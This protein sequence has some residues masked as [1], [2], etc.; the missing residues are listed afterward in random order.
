[1]K[2]TVFKTSLSIEEKKKIESDLKILKK[3]IDFSKRKGYRPVVT[4]GYGLDGIIGEIT[5][6]HGDLDIVIYANH[7]RKQIV[8]E[9]TNFIET[10]LSKPQIST[11]S[12]KFVHTID[13]NS[14]GFGGNIY[15]V[16]TENDPHSDLNVIILENKKVHKN[17]PQQFP[18]P[19]SAKLRRLIFE[20]QDPNA[21]FADILFK[22][23]HQ[24]KYNK[25]KQDIENLKQMTNLEK[26]EKLLSFYK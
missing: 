22:R 19:V 4:G 6:P 14:T 13:I 1:M 17:N 18:L 15:V 12:N 16:Q 7:N 26:V 8:K 25:H 5:R 10:L 2:T 23:K 3:L 9:V 20:A 11:H 21:H 24:R